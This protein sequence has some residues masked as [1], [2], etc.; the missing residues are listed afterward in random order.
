MR[1]NSLSVTHNIN[2]SGRHEIALR[3][4]LESNDGQWDGQVNQL[5][6]E[7]GAAQVG[8]VFTDRSRAVKH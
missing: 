7:R 4:A 6:R 1:K 3:R 2:G 5:L 8:S